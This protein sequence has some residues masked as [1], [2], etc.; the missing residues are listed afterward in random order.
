MSNTIIEILIDNSGSM[1]YMP[2][3]EHEGKNLIDG[4]TR[5]TLVKR[6]MAEHIIP[7]ID[8]SNQIIIRTFRNDSKKIDDKVVNNI[9]TPI[10]YE[11]NFDKYK[12]L[13]VVASLQDP[14]MGGTPITAAINQAVL[15]LI[16]YPDSDRKIILI[17]DGQEN[18]E[19]DFREAA[20]KA[21]QLSGIP[22][23][24]F[25]IGIAQSEEAESKSRQIAT[26][27]YYNIKTKSFV[28]DEVMR[29]LAPL[30]TAVLQNT[31]QNVQAAVKITQPQPEIQ[32][33]KVVQV[34]EEK[35]E[36]IKQE[37]RQATALQLDEL[38]SKIREQ[39]SN[40]EKLLSELSSLKELLR[41]N[42]LLETG[43]D[44]TTLT[45]DGEYS[46]SIRQRSEAF[47]YQ[48]LCSKYGAIKVKWLNE[49]SESGSQHDFELLDENGKTIQVIECKGTA[50]N[51]P[52]FYLSVNEWNHFLTN[53][54]IYQLYR[55][56]NVDGEMNAVEI[57]NLHTAIL[58]GSVVPYLLKPE[59]LK[60]GKV[61]L[62]LIK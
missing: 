30:K 42:A 5:M 1:G 46:E 57:E 43:I 50:R 60:E 23:K 55:V 24:T 56:F 10:I 8:Y 36:I 37:Y 6:I 40:T 49:N 12:I 21:E 48:L 47:L 27:G 61:F 31:V 32:Q 45:I 13:D 17:T 2:G 11:G 20:K 39:V 35:I 59:I 51:K 29:V 19:G 16:K 52:T 3:S 18:G 15:D 9:M 26:G 14:P 38:E 62:T 34:V 54:D 7:T 28:A 41:V 25:I 22:C 44:S 4:L 58:E 53:R 33:A